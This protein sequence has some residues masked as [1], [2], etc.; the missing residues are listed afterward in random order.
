MIKLE[1]SWCYSEY[2]P[3]AY[4]WQGAGPGSWVGNDLAK[5]NL[6]YLTFRG[7]L[8]AF[9]RGE[10]S[11]QQLMAR[12]DPKDFGVVSA[13]TRMELGAYMPEIRPTLVGPISLFIHRFPTWDLDVLPASSLFD[14]CWANIVMENAKAIWEWCNDT[15]DVV[16]NIQD[17]EVKVVDNV[18]KV[19]FNKKAK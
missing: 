5:W 17:T 9:V 7:H 6:I 13:T 10:I 16:A 14:G 11:I 3:Q 12:I 1:N 2:L 15:D 4:T 18:I 19:V 8:D